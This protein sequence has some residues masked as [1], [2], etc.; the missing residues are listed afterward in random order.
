V[1]PVTAPFRVY[2]SGYVVA[3]NIYIVKNSRLS[4]WWLGEG[5]FGDSSNLA[6]CTVGINT[7]ATGNT[8]V[9]FA[10]H[11]SGLPVTGDGFGTKFLVTANGAIRATAG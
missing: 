11:T 3:E 8:P 5:H 1:S 7:A 10:G 2:P 6:T 9:F 4:V